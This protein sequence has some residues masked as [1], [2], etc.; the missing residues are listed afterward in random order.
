[1]TSMMTSL[2]GMEQLVGFIAPLRIGL[3]TVGGRYTSRPYRKRDLSYDKQNMSVHTALKQDI[4][5][6]IIS[7]YCVLRQD[8]SKRAILITTKTSGSRFESPKSPRISTVSSTL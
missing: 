2:I 4:S 8:F 1:M 7:N 6:M 5:S 3:L